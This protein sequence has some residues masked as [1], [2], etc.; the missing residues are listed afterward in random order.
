MN[1]T[2]DKVIR[3]TSAY[4]TDDKVLL[5]AAALIER[6][7]TGPWRGGLTEELVGISN[8]LNLNLS[9]ITLQQIFRHAGF[10]ERAP[11]KAEGSYEYRFHPETLQTKE[12][13]NKA[14]KAYYGAQNPS[15]PI[16]PAQ[17]APRVEK[18][19]QQETAVAKQEIVVDPQ[20]IRDIRKIKLAL[21]DKATIRG[22]YLIGGL[23]AL[24]ERVIE[25]LKLDT[26]P[27]ARAIADALRLGN[28]ARYEKEPTYQGGLRWFFDPSKM[29]TD[30]EIA[31]AWRSYREKQNEMQRT[32][33]T[34][35]EK[36]KSPEYRRPEQV[37]AR[38]KPV[39]FPRTKPE[40]KLVETP[41][42]KVE[43]V[44][45]QKLHIEEGLTGRPGEAV[46]RPTYRF[47]KLNNIAK[48]LKSE[49]DRVL[50]ERDKYK[51]E[52]ATLSAKVDELTREVG[53]LERA[54]DEA[55]DPSIAE[56]DQLIKELGDFDQTGA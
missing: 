18:P 15:K 10:A 17:P 22:G 43:P 4:D 16:Q 31:D 3:V 53:R 26:A 28:F 49:L 50:A 56:A 6:V 55:K 8:E 25:D 5:V 13:A 35:Q 42:K 33:R 39:V 19:I 20:Y 11:A 51:S 24:V 46:L 12:Q 37:A 44:P 54:L 38:P 23:P 52:N 27:R 7:G 48:G 1:D 40:S 45:E 2:E 14:R 32:V 41:S 21:I 30:D 36:P 29:T 47:E 9:G 34:R